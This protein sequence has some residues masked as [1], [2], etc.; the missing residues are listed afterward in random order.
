MG[1]VPMQ[2]GKRRID[3]VLAPEFIEGLEHLDTDEIRSRRDLAKAELEYRSY[4][5]RLIQG[6]RDILKAEQ[7][8]RASGGPEGSVVDR[9]AAILADEP[10]GSSRGDAL[11][12]GVPEE[13]LV[14]ARR[15]VER[16]LADAS[17]SNVSALSDQDLEA[18]VARMDE[19]ERGVS[20]IRAQVIAA[21]DAVQDELKRRFRDE[22]RTVSG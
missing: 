20:G 19:E 21:H 16:L 22:L 14:A 5:R 3:R 1:D 10:G 17:L 2:G 4:I 18:A 9:L 11:L 6:R 8:R 12:V 15:R 7:E 13:E